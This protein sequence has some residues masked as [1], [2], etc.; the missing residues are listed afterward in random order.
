M[1]MSFMKAGGR[2]NRGD[3]AGRAG[4]EARRRGRAG[5][6]AV[7]PILSNTLTP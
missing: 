5:G 4:K 3:A 7:D 1:I 2:G 6:G